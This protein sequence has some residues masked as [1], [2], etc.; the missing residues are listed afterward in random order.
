MTVLD[1]KG[2]A[3]MFA[4]RGQDQKGRSEQ[5]SFEEVRANLSGFCREGKTA[6]R[7]ER[8]EVSRRQLQSSTLCG[9]RS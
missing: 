9:K 7:D 6:V 5:V 1:E 2:R 3:D 4:E 8:E